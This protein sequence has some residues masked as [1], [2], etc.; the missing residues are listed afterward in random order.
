MMAAYGDMLSLAA[1]GGVPRHA[2]EK[3]LSS[4]LDHLA[5]AAASSAASAAAAAPPPPSPGGAA[6]APPPPAAA[7]SLLERV[8]EATLAAL[9]A[10]NE[11]LAFRT[12][13]RLAGL[14]LGRGDLAAAERA[15]AALRA[16]CGGIPG[17]DAPA[18]LTAAD[19]PAGGG[20]PPGAAAAAAAVD[21]ARRGTQL[22]DVLA[23][24]I[25]ASAARGD[26]R[27]SRAAHRAALGALATAIPHPRVMGAIKE[28]GGRAALADRDWAGAATSFFEAFRAYD[29]AGAPARTRC[30]RGAVVASLLMGTGV[31]PFEAVEARPYR[32]DPEVASV[33]A[34][35]DAHQAGDAAA[36]GR[37]LAR[38]ARAL[39]GDPV[40]AAHLGDLTAG[41]RGAA[42]LRAV[43]PYARVRVGHV[44]AELGISPAEA[45]AVLASLILA[46]RL[47]GRIDQEAGLLEVGG[48]GAAEGQAPPPQGQAPDRAASLAAWAGAVGGLHAAVVG[49]MS[50]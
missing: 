50:A 20:K 41:V 43:A 47:D 46:G 34:L 45:E 17:L 5:A 33:A 37:A 26:A 8:Y 23:L 42:A 4:L 48:G 44:A 10:S 28:A 40:V 32:A 6:A 21:D 15:L 12:R 16:S 25:Q 14:W 31:D 38:H 18:A 24:E 7:E 22:L 3:K 49:R 39:G 9:G 29:E 30:L 19:N 27:R 13:L 11:R 35:A 36:F 1:A 2:A